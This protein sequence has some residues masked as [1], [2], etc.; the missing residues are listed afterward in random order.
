MEDDANEHLGSSHPVSPK[1]ND[2]VIGD[3]G[4]TAEEEQNTAPLHAPFHQSALP[5]PPVPIATSPNNN[6]NNAKWEET[7]LFF[8]SAVG[9]TLPWTAVLSN[10]VYYTDTLGVNSYLYL[11]VCIYAPLFPMTCAQA[12]WDADFDRR[13]SSL[14]SFGSRGTLG[15]GSLLGATLLM[16]SG[17]AQRLWGVSSL[18]LVMGTASGALHGALKQMASFVYPGC[19]RLAAAVTAGLQASA[20]FV[21]VVGLVVF[22]TS[23][24]TKQSSLEGFYVVIA[25]IL[26]LCWLCF[27][28]LMTHSRDVYQSMLRR[29]SS[30]QLSAMGGEETAALNSARLAAGCN[31]DANGEAESDLLFSYES[32]SAVLLGAPASPSP[33]DRSEQAR[34]LL[35]E[36]LLPGHR[37][38]SGSSHT[39]SGTM[40]SQ[41]LSLLQQSWPLCVAIFLT[42]GSSMAVASWF[43]RVPS[44]ASPPNPNLPQVLFY[45]R[46]FADLLARPATLLLPTA[47]NNNNTKATVW[48]LTSLVVL[49]LL[50]VPYFFLYCTAEPSSKHG[51]SVVATIRHFR[52]DMMMILGVFGFAFSSGFI[53]TWVYQLAPQ[54]CRT[55]TRN[56]TNGS[57]SEDDNRLLQQTNLLNVCFSASVL[58]GLM[59]SLG[60][61]DG[62]R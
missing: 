49:R 59:G 3:T 22:N 21:L 15:F 39:S 25:V 34:L 47:T 53:T 37:S 41:W 33:D 35:G 6:N 2:A 38:S 19:G 8:A 26:G 13:Y 20:V 40:M 18:A 9:C 24:D 1:N 11:N 27:Q 57:T 44:H 55:T 30:I 32:E 52:G 45:T 14:T 28:R 16:G 7:L 5:T 56:N 43:N 51:S 4:A 12:L 31:E 62:W 10:L 29:D 60:L 46:L 48:S 54:Y 58:V 61:S 50:F 23:H 42:V 36:P 17:A